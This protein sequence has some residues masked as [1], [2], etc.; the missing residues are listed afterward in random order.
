ME[1]VTKPAVTVLKDETLG[2]IEREY[3][4][5]KR[6]AVVG[7]RIKVI[8]ARGSFGDYKTGNVLNVAALK[9]F[10]F[11]GVY[12]KETAYGWSNGFALRHDEYVVLEPTDIVRINGGRY[13]L[14]EREAKPGE[15]VIITKVRKGYGYF[16]LGNVGKAVRNNYVDFNGEGNVGYNADDGIWYVC[17]S[18][19]NSAY[20]VLE[21]VAPANTLTP[22]AAE[23]D[24]ALLQRQVGDILARVT[25]LELDVKVARE[26]IVVAADIE[27]L[28]PK[29]APDS[30]DEIVARAKADVEKLST[31]EIYNKETG[32]SYWPRGCE[33]RGFGAIREV[34]FV[35]NREKRTV[36]ALVRRIGGDCVQYRGIAKAAPGDCFDVHIG[37]AIALRRALALPIPADYVNA[38][39]PT[40]PRVGD[41]ISFPIT[42]SW[43]GKVNYR[44]DTLEL[45]ENLTIVH[46]VKGLC[47]VGGKATGANFRNGYGGLVCIDDSRDGTDAEAPPK[48]AGFKKGDRVR[49]TG[50]NGV[51]GDGIGTIN[52]GYKKGDVGVVKGISPYGNY[53][54]HSDEHSGFFQ[55]VS[56]KNVEAA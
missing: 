8:E 15:K 29:P 33:K 11:E 27:R 46:D 31:T 34:E 16:S 39:Q 23:S 35:V 25:K 26:G 38:P 10:G 51:S 14:D 24:I 7:E 37:K 12:T 50:N 32:R 45:G 21:P 28:K 4:E 42:D 48:A 47:C 9:T 54:V 6:A 53:E 52:H 19:G 56:P 3:V 55:Y 18:S 22:P 43:H 2:G 30:R 17:A 1:N 5:V 40:E 49:I 13:R 36:V 44:I 20:A 41:I